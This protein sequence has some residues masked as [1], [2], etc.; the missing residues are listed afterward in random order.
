MCVWGLYNLKA[1]L[2]FCFQRMDLQVLSNSSSLLTSESNIC[3]IVFAKKPPTTGF[4]ASQT[5]SSH[6]FFLLLVE[7][8]LFYNCY[9]NKLFFTFGCDLV[10]EVHFYINFVSMLWQTFV[11]VMVIFYFLPYQLTAVLP[12]IFFMH[13]STLS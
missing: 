10:S 2:F 1:T 11:F 9:I 5:V 3:P 12:M 6:L 13:A 8:Q 4:I 7:L